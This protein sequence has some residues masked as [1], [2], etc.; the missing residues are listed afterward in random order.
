MT[1][2]ISKLF[3][4]IWF[5]FGLIVLLVNDFVL[6]ELYGNWLTGKLS[7]FAGIFIFSL[8]WVALFPKHKN[9]IFTL[10]ALLFIYWKSPFSQN[11]IDSWNNLGLLKVYRTVDYSD[12]MAL[13][14]LPFAYYIYDYKEKLLTINL[15]PYIP[16]AFCIFAFLATS[17]PKSNTYFDDNTAVYHIKHNSRDSFMNELYSIN[18]DITSSKYNDTKYD[19]EHTE[20]KNLNDSIGNLVIM[21]RDF[22]ESNQTIE[23]SLENWDYKNKP[24]QMFNK[25]ELEAQRAYVKSIFEQKVISKLKK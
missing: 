25:D 3:T 23:I 7:D 18:L 20:I 15:S 10:I 17:L 13:I 1:Q 2:N 14:M 6:K 19:D 8:F 21:V 5:L 9:K 4:S 22:N 16:F 24:N 11:L 12:T